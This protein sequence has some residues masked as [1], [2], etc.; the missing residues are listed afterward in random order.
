MKIIPAV[1]FGA[2]VMPLPAL[3]QSAEPE[4]MR[5]QEQTQGS[6]NNS[7]TGAPNSSV[8]RNR[9]DPAAPSPNRLQVDDGVA[10]GVRQSPDVNTAHPG[11]GGNS[12][13]TVTRGAAPSTGAVGSPGA[14]SVG[15]TGA[16]AGVGGTGA[17]GSVGGTGASGGVGGT[18]AGG[19][20]GG[21]AG[22]GGGS[23]GGGGG[24]GGGS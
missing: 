21:S 10:A 12:Y 23:G 2:L 1:M 8:E 19:A 3:A 22:G 7:T 11:S 17:S 9:I 16:G 4:S 24:G 6:I 5:I 15:G 18:G 14:G 20:A 13:N